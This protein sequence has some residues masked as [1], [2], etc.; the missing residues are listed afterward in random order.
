MKYCGYCGN[1]I[2]DNANF[3]PHCGARSDN[4]ENTHEVDLL[5]NGEETYNTNYNYNNNYNVNTSNSNVFAVLAFIFSFLS[6][7]MGWIFASIGKRKAEETGV[8]Y[9]FCKAA[10]INLQLILF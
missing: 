10:M 1:E 7:I 5:I 6:P 9:G 4:H 8:G 2:D 3:C